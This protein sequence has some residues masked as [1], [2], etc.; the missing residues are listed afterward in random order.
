VSL[1]KP[2]LDEQRYWNRKLSEAGFRDAEEVIGG[3]HV[4]KQ[5]AEHPYRGTDDLTRQTKAA[6]YRLLAQQSHDTEFA[7]EAHKLILTMYA[8]GSKIRDI[9]AALEAQGM[10][11]CRGSIRFIIR[12]YEMQ[13]GLRQYSLKQLNKAPVEKLEPAP[14]ARYF[15]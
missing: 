10:C 4:L 14:L 7:N 12:K 13:W 8:E 11:R 9:C 5:T 3:E 15:R 6:Y 2:T 1:R